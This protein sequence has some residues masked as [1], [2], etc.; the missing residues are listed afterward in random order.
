MG[1]FYTTLLVRGASRDSIE[2]WLR[3]Q[4]R[5]AMVLP[6]RDGVT[7][8]FDKKC[9]SQSQ[10][11]IILFSGSISKELKCSAWAVMNRDD[12]MLVYQLYKEGELVDQYSSVKAA[13]YFGVVESGEFEEEDESDYA[14]TGGDATVLCELMGNGGDCEAVASSLTDLGPMGGRFFD[15]S[16]RHHALLRAL[17]IDPADLCI[18][19]NYLRQSPRGKDIIYID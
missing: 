9:E 6:T 1:A 18:G 13:V 4:Q 11:E 8:V 14:P 3:Q 5:R 7:P 10:K 15:A 12:D 16:E 17:G 2:S 19:Y